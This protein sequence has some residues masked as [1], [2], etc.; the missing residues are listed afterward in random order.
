LEV[1]IKMRDEL[2]Q[3]ASKRNQKLGFANDDLL[4]KIEV[5]QETESSLH[6]ELEDLKSSKSNMQM[7]MKAMNAKIQDIRQAQSEE[8]ENMCDMIK[9]SKSV[10]AENDRLYREM[11]SSGN[12]C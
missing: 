3:T 4:E 8:Y 10:G 5:F 9:K 1:E 6:H 7:T 2:I 12:I 11:T